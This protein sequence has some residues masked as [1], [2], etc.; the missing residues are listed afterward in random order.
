MPQTRV[1]RHWR[2]TE[3]AGMWPPGSSK[4]WSGHGAQRQSGS[5][6]R[7]PGRPSLVLAAPRAV[8]A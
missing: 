8:G 4:A 1:R 3:A 7:V 5:T 2:A 6:V